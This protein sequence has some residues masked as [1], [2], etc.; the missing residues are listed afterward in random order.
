MAD[1]IRNNHLGGGGGGCHHVQITSVATNSAFC[2]R[3][4]LQTPESRSNDYSSI[5]H[6]TYAYWRY[7]L[8]NP[9]SFATPFLYVCS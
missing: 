4:V 9:N 3:I 6:S 8:K 1:E 2:E 5:L 7:I